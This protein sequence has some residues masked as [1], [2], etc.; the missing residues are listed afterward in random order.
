MSVTS[1]RCMGASRRAAYRGRERR[2]SGF[3]LIDFR[4]QRLVEGQYY[5]SPSTP[6]RISA[7][8]YSRRSNQRQ[9]DAG[10]ANCG[11]QAARSGDRQFLLPETSRA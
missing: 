6:R 9:L 7:F 2:H 1:T 8:D 3:D 11:Q 10:A 4:P 5:G